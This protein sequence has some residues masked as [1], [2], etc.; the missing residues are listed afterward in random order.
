MKIYKKSN[1]ILLLIALLAATAVAVPGL[2]GCTKTSENVNTSMKNHTDNTT[3]NSVSYFGS[4]AS[5]R[6]PFVPTEPISQ[7][8]AKKRQAYYVG[9]YNSNKQ[10]ERFEKYLDGKLEWQDKY[11]YWDN[12]KLKNRYMIKADGSETIQNFDRD[13]NM[14]K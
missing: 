8:E 1:T 5:H 11:V 2:S 12:E 7:E 4:W 14:I 6:I 10:L 13:G 9:Y 3:S